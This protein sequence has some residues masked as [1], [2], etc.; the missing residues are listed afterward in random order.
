MTYAALLAEVALYL[1][2]SD[3]TER[4]VLWADLA[5]KS[6]ERGQFIL[7]GKSVQVN[8]NCMKKRQTT[9]SDETYITMPSQI[10]EVR[11]V[12]ILFETRYYD[13]TQRSPEDAMTLYPYVSGAGIPEDRPKIYAFLEEQSEILVRPTPDQSY[14][15]DI[16]FYAYSDLM[17]VTESNW[18]LTNAWELLLYGA[19]LQAEPY[20]INDAR[21]ATWKAYFEEGIMKLAKAEK[22]ASDAGKTMRVK[23]YLPAQLRA[24]SQA[25][26]IETIE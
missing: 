25:F 16:G 8:W 18:W 9:S 23:P 13:L 12:K 19:L 2:R 3:L 24:G 1:N 21:T 6:I 7:D 17:T 5:K 20:I 22:S 15:Y 4:I 14:T 10:K 11:W 26:D